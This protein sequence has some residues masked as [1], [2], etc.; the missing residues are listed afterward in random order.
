MVHLFLLKNYFEVIGSG[1]PKYARG[2]N[3]ITAMTENVYIFVRCFLEGVL[4][5]VTMA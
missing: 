1:S 3:E 2:S 4:R 5:G